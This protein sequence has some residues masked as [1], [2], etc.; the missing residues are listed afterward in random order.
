MVFY[1]G[2]MM[3]REDLPRQ[4]HLE[5]LVPVASHVYANGPVSYLRMNRLPES[6]DYAP[7]VNVLEGG[8]YFVTSGEVLIPAHSYQGSGVDMSITA[9]V[10]WTF[11][12]DF[13]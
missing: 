6:G 1:A 10:E 12:L 11:P 7:I 13:V 3:H 9:E 8:D 2:V 4:T 5:F